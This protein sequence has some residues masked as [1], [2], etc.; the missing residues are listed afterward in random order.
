MVVGGII[1]QVITLLSVLVA[2]S[3]ADV[4]KLG[5]RVSVAA[6]GG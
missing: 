2:L 5:K 3:V 6:N 1:G 4:I